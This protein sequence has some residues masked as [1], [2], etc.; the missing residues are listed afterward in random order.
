MKLPLCL[1]LTAACATTTLAVEHI[2][3]HKF[4]HDRFYVTPMGQQCAYDA[5]IDPT[6]YP[7]RDNGLCVRLNETYGECR[8]QGGS[9]IGSDESDEEDVGDSDSYDSEDE[10]ASGSG[11]VAVGSASGS[12]SHKSNAVNVGDDDEEDDEDDDDDDDDEEETT[13]PVTKKV[14]KAKTAPHKMHDRFYVTPMGQQCAYNASID[15]TMYPCRDNGVC[16]RLNETYGECQPTAKKVVKKTQVVKK[17]EVAKKTDAAP[18]KMHSKLYFAEIGGQCAYNASIDP[19]MYGCRDQGVCVRLNETYG[20]C[21][22][23]LS[24]S[25][26]SGSD[27]SDS[28]TDVGDSESDDESGSGSNS[29]AVGD[30]EVGSIDKKTSVKSPAKQSED[31]DEDEED[32]DEEDSDD[33][34]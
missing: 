29:T 1:A 25:S 15:P 19:S 10:E 12:G 6:M 30:V 11:S 14:V 33:E 26:A 20:E 4:H 9:A 13:P 34:N 24:S 21:R 3:V 23:Q 2:R 22:P 18:H 32:E 27:D 31:D 7:C 16:V 8:P 5:S 28:E 17:T